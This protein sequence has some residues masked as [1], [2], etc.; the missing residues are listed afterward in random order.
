MATVIL[1]AGAIVDILIEGWTYRFFAAAI[2]SSAGT[3]TIDR[4][5]AGRP[6]AKTIP[7]VDHDRR[8]SIHRTLP[9]TPRAGSNRGEGVRAEIFVRG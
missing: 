8:S 9:M 5:F 3:L 7:R 1:G 6:N 4:C 2:T